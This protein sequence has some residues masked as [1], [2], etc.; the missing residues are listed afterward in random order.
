MM[1]DRHPEPKG[2]ILGMPWVDKEKCTGCGLCVETCPVD[3]IHIENDI[4][5]INMDNCIRCGRCHDICPEEAVRH[6]G[7]KIP[8]EVEANIAGALQKMDA[9]AHFFGEEERQKCL[10]RIMKSFNKEKMVAEKTL[11]RLEALKTDA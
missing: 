10:A 9:C 6:D 11:E 5:E 1:Q 8:A 7:E 4:A 2:G 3:T